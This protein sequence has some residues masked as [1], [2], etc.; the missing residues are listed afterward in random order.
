M[1]ERTAF[2]VGAGEFTPRGLRP[3]PGDAVVAADGGHDA[4]LRHG[5]RADL[6]VGD[7]DSV[8][9]PIRSVARLRFPAKKDDTDMA[10]AVR[11]MAARGFTRFR[12]YGALGGRLDHSVANLHLLADMSRRGLRAAITAPGVTVFG[13]T[14]GE[15]RFPPLPRGRV[16]SVFAWGGEARGVTLR[17]L[18]YPL[19]D[20]SLSPFRA[21][22]VSNEALGRPFSISCREGT[23]L[24]VLPE[25]AQKPE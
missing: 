21:L 25:R 19:K 10:L 23:L 12:L 11:L 15:L 5:I 3:L 22:G 1:R 7:M 24:V 16:V 2:I 8:I 13:V 14:A 9:L 4:L 6:V 17:G 18:A 20:A